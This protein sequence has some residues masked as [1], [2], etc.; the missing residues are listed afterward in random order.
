MSVLIAMPSELGTYIGCDGRM[1]V[2]DTIVPENVCKWVQIR[3]NLW[4]GIAGAYRAL[5]LVRE[6][7]ATI[8]DELSAKGLQDGASQARSC[9]A[10]VRAMLFRDGWLDEAKDGK[11]RWLDVEML[12]AWPGGTLE[13]GGTG[14]SYS[15]DQHAA[16]GSGA[17]VALG[18]LDALSAVR[19]NRT[20]RRRMSIPEENIRAAIGIAMRRDC[21]CGGEVFVMRVGA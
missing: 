11:P 19:R 20:V 9:A 21:G 2:G 16:I 13:V 12:I 7:A 10:L 3:E 18:A 4:A 15:V 17:R 8:A 6:G 1:T 5:E 14:S